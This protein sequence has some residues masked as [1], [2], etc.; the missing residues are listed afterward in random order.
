MSMKSTPNQLKKNLAKTVA[1]GV[2]GAIALSGCSA[3]SSNSIPVGC[4]PAV[5]TSSVE[6]FPTISHAANDRLS[7]A[8]ADARSQGIAIPELDKAKYQGLLQE[9]TEV[10]KRDSTAQVCV[11]DLATPAKVPFIGQEG[12]T[13]IVVN[14]AT[15]TLRTNTDGSHEAALFDK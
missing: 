7:A 11:G 2:A 15:D 4:S 13:I 8:L 12:H 3:K 14:P 10:V 1:A 5:Q 6:D 9:A